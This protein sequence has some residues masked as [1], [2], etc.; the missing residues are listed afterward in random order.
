MTRV[1]V[2]LDLE[3]TGLD[4]TRDAIIEIGMVKFRG[5]EVLDT[6]TSLVNPERPLPLKIQ[7]LVGISEKELSGAP[8]LRTLLGKIIRF[9]G[10]SPIVGHNIEFDLAF[11]RRNELPLNN[12]AIDTFELATIT[13]P[14]AGRYSL[15]NLTQLLGIAYEEHHRA[16]GDAE[17]TRLLFL[18][19]LEKLNTWDITLLEEITQAS[20]QSDWPLKQLLRDILLDRKSA[21]L[22][23]IGQIDKARTNFE[24]T[25]NEKPLP[26]LVPAAELTTLDAD[27]LALMISPGGSV[28]ATVDG[29]EHR[30]EQVDMLRAVCDAF[31]TPAHLL[32]EAGTGVGKSIAYLLP[33]IYFSS[34]NGQ[35]VVISS[36][37]INLQ[38]QL[39]HKDIPTL[40]KA[41]SVSFSV[42]VLKG[43]SNYLCLRQL[44]VF[45]R[46]RQLSAEE[47]RVLAK[48]LFWKQKTTTGDRSELL[49]INT[50]NEVW[51]QL[52]ASPDTCLHDLCPY[53]QSNQ[54]FF[55]RARDRAERANLII[56]N[57][58]LLLSDLQLENR[59][60]PE[61][62]YLVIDEAHHLEDIA[63]DQFGLAIDSRDLYAF[64]NSLSYQQGAAQ[65]GLFGDI[66]GLLR[67]A[68]VSAE[69]QQTIYDLLDSMRDSIATAQHHL[70]DVFLSIERFVNEHI[71][72]RNSADSYDERISL[73]EGLRQQPAWEE[74]EVAWENWSVPSTALLDNLIKLQKLID[75]LEVEELEL[76]QQFTLDL[77]SRIKQG[78]ELFEGLK[79]ILTEPSS[80]D[81]YWLTI[82]RRDGRISVNS[83]P[84]S[85]AELLKEKLF[86]AKSSIILTSATLRTADEF[87]YIKDRLGLDDPAELALGSPFN[88]KSAALLYVPNDL[89]EPNQ[90]NYQR[91]V[92]KALVELCKATEG[93]TMALFT[94]TSQ[95]NT[96]YR[97]IQRPLEEE[98]IVVF[99]QGADGSR[100][101]ILDNFRNS[102]KAVLLGTRS[103]WEGV[104]VVGQALSCL[105]I[106]RLPFAVPTDPI[107]AA[108]SS[109]FEDPFGQYS[110]PDAILRFRQGFGRLIRSKEDYG[111]VV[112][113]DKR[114]LTKSYGKLML[115]S[116]PPCTARQGPLEALPNAA[117]RWLDPANRK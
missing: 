28:A 102:D 114:L 30:Q 19:L 23:V 73:T 65:A 16:L 96:T 43:Y 44:R 79:H 78:L 48:V 60:L 94:S 37:T 76:K 100:R 70:Q 39:I 80:N 88:F 69:K 93:R 106:V 45:R 87:K 109:T 13:M 90:P 33:S 116:L 89:P 75:P 3:T 6:F 9:V 4:R 97:A 84:L 86:E 25:V 2:A 64:L 14:E 113:L 61:Y 108:R 10:T 1:Y 8:V 12:L 15:A 110:L 72:Q 81:I 17:A 26:P 5:N 57:H 99:A 74:V 59:I 42:A 40:E 51:S 98:G 49:L 91:S 20:Q 56:V 58:A 103:F 34:Q 35:R 63:T 38:D 36:N 52:Q 21:A 67:T 71:D 105:V 24:Q 50:E 83:A 95:L 18:S 27:Q 111:I 7:Q 112:V 53:R 101:Q 85:V 77:S 46:N 104:D 82:F 62:E 66:P 11:L 29:F 117:R 115:R 68:K 107:T 22:P 41:V 32:V 31:N 54:C 55:Y 92:E 47:G